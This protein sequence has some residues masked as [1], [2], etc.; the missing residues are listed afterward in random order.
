MWFEDMYRHQVFKVRKRESFEAWGLRTVPLHR[1]ASDAIGGC[2]V[3]GEG[4]GAYGEERKDGE[5]H[6]WSFG[7]ECD[8]KSRN[9]VF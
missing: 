3:L 2:D 7:V 9:S 1:H 5:L 6:N 4:E 8:E